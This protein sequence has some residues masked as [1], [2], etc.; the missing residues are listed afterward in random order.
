MGRIVATSEIGQHR[1]DDEQGEGVGKGL[2]LS[3]VVCR[4]GGGGERHRSKLDRMASD[5]IRLNK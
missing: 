4:E 3:S 1:N 2:G 5:S